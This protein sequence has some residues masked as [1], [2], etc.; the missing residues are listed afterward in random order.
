M[1]EQARWT[2]IEGR[3]PAQQKH[4]CVGAER[5]KERSTRQGKRA[6]KTFFVRKSFFCELAEMTFLSGKGRGVGE[7]L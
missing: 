5:R 3:P 6:G 4:V 7:N 2:T 1:L